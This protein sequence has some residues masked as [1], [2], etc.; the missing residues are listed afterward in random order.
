VIFGNP[1]KFAIQMDVVKAWSSPPTFIEGVVN[2]YLNDVLLGE[3]YAYTSSIFQDYIDIVD[4]VLAN[5][6]VVSE[7][8]FSS[9]V[10]LILPEI[11]KARHP[12]L[13]FD[14]DVDYESAPDELW[15]NT[16]ED[17]SKDAT[18]ETLLKKGYK[19]FAIKCKEA[20]RLMV[21]R[22]DLADGGYFDL[23]EL[24]Y[25]DIQEVVVGAE[26]LS[27]LVECIDKWYQFV[28]GVCEK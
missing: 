11:L 14:S 25:A 7:E 12:W 13:V 21:L 26:Y 6:S 28:Q 20:V 22:F 2:V 16:D 5:P 9:D 19:L 18:F 3:G 23:S 8:E 15:S 24:N 27:D 1:S 4:G 10:A 17:L